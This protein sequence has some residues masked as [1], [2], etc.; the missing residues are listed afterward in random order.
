LPLSE[1]NCDSRYY[2]QFWV[3]AVRWLAAG[4]Q[5][6]TNSPVALELARSYTTPEGKVTA[7]VK[8]RD[9]QGRDVTGA[10]VSVVLSAPQ[11]SSVSFHA[12]YDP[13][14]RSYVAQL[15]AGARG[16]YTVTA[17]ATRNGE[18]LGQDQQLLVSEDVEREMAE[19]RAQPDLM[20]RL[21]KLSG[22]QTFTPASAELGNIGATFA[23]KPEEI[24][25]YQRRPLWDK[26]WLLATVLGLLALEWSF[27]RWKGL[28]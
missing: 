5:G 20:A 15:S 17:M 13:S 10:A 1:T 19:I 26:A 12:V 8:V 7:S 21:P 16:D 9:P 14:S 23:N 4:K 25:E 2:R 22:G 28:A 24:I 27:R 11:K 3:N 6:K 18:Q